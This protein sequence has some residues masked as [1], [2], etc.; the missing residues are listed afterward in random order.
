MM[1]VDW[2]KEV[3]RYIED[4]SKLSCPDAVQMAEFS[5]Y[6]HGRWE[7]LRERG[8]DKPE[9]QHHWGLRFHKDGMDYITCDKCGESK[10]EYLVQ[11][12]HGLGSGRVK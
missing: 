4:Y 10:P 9:C 2:E 12:T 5:A 1:K 3:R 6:W 8:E 7:A 11:L